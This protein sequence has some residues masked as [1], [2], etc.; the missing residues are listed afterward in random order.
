MGSGTGILLVLCHCVLHTALFCTISKKALQGFVSARY[1][2]QQ[3]ICMR[4]AGVEK[5]KACYKQL[6]SS[7]S[8]NGL[9]VILST[10]TTQMLH[11]FWNYAGMQ[12]YHERAD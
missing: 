1:W 5:V 12:F 2:A 11:L 8:E 10:G 3:A 4:P 7:R 9:L 6:P